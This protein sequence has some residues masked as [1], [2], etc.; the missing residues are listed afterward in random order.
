[1]SCGF[2]ATDQDGVIVRSRHDNWVSHITGEHPEVDGQQAAVATTIRDP[3]Y[4]Y[5]D[6][7]YAR[8][9]LLCRPFMLPQSFYNYYLRVVVEYRGD[10]SRRRGTVVTAFVSAD[11]R[12]GDVL[13]WSKYETTK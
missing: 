2:E 5:Q 13:I 9:R 3:V 6:N 11:I 8:R 4:I 10:G 12:E 1:M 7:R